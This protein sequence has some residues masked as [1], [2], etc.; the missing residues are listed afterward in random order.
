MYFWSYNKGEFKDFYD[1]I[2]I[3][4]KINF[5]NSY[6]LI[7]VFFYLVRCVERM[8]EILVVEKWDLIILDEV[9]YVC[10]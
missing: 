10:C 4:N 1:N 8:I 2:L 9:Y 3:I 5:W 6:K 7:L